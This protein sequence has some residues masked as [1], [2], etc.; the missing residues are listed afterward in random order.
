MNKLN[1]LSEK[2]WNTLAKYAKII[3]TAILK[4]LPVDW[5]LEFDEVEGV[6]FDSFVKIIQSYNPNGTCS[7]A[8]YCWK[9]A[10]K[11]AL[12]TLLKEY[13]RQ[14]SI[15][16]LYAINCL[17]DGKDD[18]DDEGHIR[19]KIIKDADFSVDLKNPAAIYE[20]NETKQEKQ[21]MTKKII[22]FAYDNGY[23]E[24]ATLLMFK[25]EREIAEQL[26]IS[27]PAVHKKIEKFRQ[28]VKENFSIDEQ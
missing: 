20:E 12:T 23:G 10:G 1:I 15:D 21:H 4:K 18:D 6:I 14:K 28:L 5:N 26:G 19:H 9:Y 22:D 7:V 16:T 27:Q 8:S 3:A 2:D 11:M 24:L 13:R 25:S 17:D